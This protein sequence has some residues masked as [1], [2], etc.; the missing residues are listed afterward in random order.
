MAHRPMS[1]QNQHR[2][3][4]DG[5]ENRNQQHQALR[6]SEFGEGLAQV[7][8]DNTAED[9]TGPDQAVE[10]FRFSR[11]QDVIGQSPTLSGRKHAKNSYPN[12]KDGKQPAE[13]IIAAEIP[14]HEAVGGE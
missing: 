2:Y 10:P 3:D 12:I 8:A 9:A 11:R 7:T 13:M 1:S 6:A 5:Q 4:S 14:E